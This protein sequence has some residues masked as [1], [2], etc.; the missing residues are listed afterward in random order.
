VSDVTYVRTGHSFSYVAFV[1]DAFA[2]RV[3]GWQTDLAPQRGPWSRIEDLEL[4]TLEWVW[5]FNNRRLFGPLG[6]V[7]DERMSFRRGVHFRCGGLHRYPR[8]PRYTRK[9]AIPFIGPSHAL[10]S[11]SSVGNPSGAR[12][13]HR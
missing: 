9:R 11:H 13:L 12:R 8:Y 4:A 3:V 1:S 10:S 6:W 2:R 5:W 7:A